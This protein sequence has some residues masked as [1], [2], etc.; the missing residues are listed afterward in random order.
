M[1]W[2]VHMRRPSLMLRQLGPWGFAG[3]F[4]CAVSAARNSGIKFALKSALSAP[5]YWPLHSWA[6]S[7][8]L[9]ELIRAPH[10]WAKTEHGLTKSGASL[11]HTQI[12]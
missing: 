3:A 10:L 2:L 1:T 11:V 8:A 5:V 12:A 9:I 7:L 6:A 4:A